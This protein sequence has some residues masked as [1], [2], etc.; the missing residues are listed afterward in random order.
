[1]AQARARGDR[2]NTESAAS[3]AA[4]EKRPMPADMP[5]EGSA[6]VFVIESKR[7]EPESPPELEPAEAAE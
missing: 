4:Q 5:G 1:M 6:K 7:L 3:I 2:A